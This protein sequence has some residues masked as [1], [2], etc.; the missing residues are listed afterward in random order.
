MSAP[1]LKS[2]TESRIAWLVLLAV[3][4]F[5]GALL[6]PELA[7]SRVDLNDNVFHFAL[8]ERMAQ[9]L[10]RGENP[11]D[12]WSPEWSLGYPVLRTYQPL[13]HLLVLGAWLALGKSVSLMTVFVWVR[14]L[15]VALL[16]LS[17][18]AAARLLGLRPITAAAAALLAPMVSTNFLYGVEY[19]SFTWA[20]SGL[21][22]QS[23]ATHFLLLALGLGYR[24]I[25]QGRGLTLAG[26]M[27]GL[28]FLAHYIYGYIGALSLCLLAAM[29]DEKVELTLRIRRTLWIGAAAG[30][31]AAFQ[32]APLLM[33]GTINHSRWEAAWKWDSYGS[34]QVLEWLFT[35][36]LLD[37]ARLPML[38]LLAFGGAGWFFWR[39]YRLRE[40]DRAHAFVLMGAG[41]WIAMFFG[42]PLWGSLLTLLG[43]SRDM[44][45]HRVIGGAQIFLVLLAA[46][47][48]TAVGGELGRRR[49][50]G[51]AAV[52]LVVL[53]YPMVK[54]RAQNLGN[55][56]DWGRK[57]LVAY[58][59]AR[60]SIDATIQRVKERGGRVYPGLAAAWGGRFKVG[61]V[62]LYAFL[63]TAQVPA[64]AFLYHSM[65]LTSD[66]MVRF[67][68]W[69][70]DHYR[71]FNIQTVVAPAEG[72]PLLPPFD[73]PVE[74]IGR[75]RILAAPGGGYFDL[76]EV[77]AAVTVSRNNFYDVNDRWL[78][79]NWV[80]MRKHL[81][82]DWR[83]DAPRSM[84]RIGPEDPL[85]GITP[86]APLGAV[87][88]DER[89]GEVYEASFHAARD[90]YVLFKMTWHPN[91]KAELDGKPA[92]A[93]MVSPGF[94]AVAV[95]AGD[96]R[97]RFHYQPE[98]WRSAGAILG[99]LVVIAMAG[100]RRAWTL[101]F[102]VAATPRVRI[103]A[104]LL[105]LALPVCIPLLSS[106]LLDGHDAFVYFP[107]LVE[108]HQSIAN[109]ILLPRWAPDLSSGNG[110]PFFFSPPL[111]YYI[112]E[113]F[114]LLGFS[115]VT[116]MNLMCVVIVL[117]SAVAMFLLGRL[118]FGTRGG[119]L[120]AAALL[121]APYFAVNL[122]VRSDMAEFA[123]FPFCALAL[124]GFGAYAKQGRRRAL[125]LG[126]AA[127]AGVLLAHN[128]W[129][130]IFA[131][132]LLA[133]LIFTSWRAGW[134][135]LL[136]QAAGFMLGLGL[137]AAS[138]VPGFLERSDVQMDR[139]LQGY[140]RYSNH[141]VYLQQLVHSRWGYG[142]SVAGPNDQMSF[143]LGW[144]L[145]L[146]AV[147]AWLLAARR[148]DPEDRRTM[149]FF[150]AACAVFC[151]LT[152]QDADWIWDRLPLLPY[153]QFPWRLLGP[154]AICMALLLA[155]LGRLLDEWPRWR[156]WAFAAAMALV[157]V[158][159][160][161]HLAPK[162]LRDVDPAFWTPRAIAARGVE[163][164]TAG[165]YKPRWVHLVPPYRPVTAMVV[166]GEAELRPTR[167]T[168]IS[169]S[170]QVTAKQASSV[171]LAISWFP[172]WQVRIDGAPAEA[173][174][175]EPTGQ[176]R[177]D[178]PAGDHRVEAVWARTP[179][180]WLG[181]GISLASLVL[182]IAAWGW[183]K[184]A[185]G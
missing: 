89:H 140:L 6:R 60:A 51:V 123:A 96:H 166:N 138:L 95:P 115:F 169:W 5:N 44:Q 20:G 86:T 163:V 87:T 167:R 84:A 154:A 94:P 102:Y 103:A 18:F 157:I 118:Y 111:V 130:L 56:A 41:F 127:Y 19:G 137:A 180:M 73:V 22:T 1:F 136:P 100:A 158:P 32:L 3:L 160:L 113:F 112:G 81:L 104:G 177:F 119:W 141:F 150:T 29:P 31:L 126:A 181:D 9:A 88:G 139:L 42:R 97:I 47:G 105:L 15:A 71:L 80:G 24:A 79:S 64:V 27:L 23:V 34:G 91:W 109:G 50:F 164:T 14:F 176:I 131:P 85:P 98:W 26:A 155:P 77:P 49:R 151:F 10:D 12:C 16:P 68:E 121:Y 69:N 178:V 58:E 72:G 152:L 63:S 66:L 124:Y 106:H 67:N 54:E 135:S 30:A 149:K 125:L 76:I 40:I 4:L 7:I 117:I 13:A 161:S 170:A 145:L 184:R 107:R 143:S 179:A 146:L 99:L 108:F 83:G 148:S 147:A 182:L 70:P 61:D 65:A 35:G 93:V 82:L 165:E 144:S 114:H 133:F 75:F 62:Q 142:L 110:Q 48:L 128:G 25:R 53:L 156:N 172:G 74:R 175:A 90:C 57:N 134:R 116:S 162:Q 183:R 33:D 17:F 8:I 185:A 37:H 101:Q 43:V 21:F 38:T 46:I 45:L 2:V 11:L 78:V 122:F 159:N 171:Q 153:L 39:R 129:A 52:A 36:E 92:P 132:L 173:Q 28:T 59:T 174:P 168:P 55:D 120:A